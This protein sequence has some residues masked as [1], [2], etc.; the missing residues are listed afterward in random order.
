MKG[1]IKAISDGVNASKLN[2]DTVCLATNQTSSKA[3]FTER[4]M[5]RGDQG[6]SVGEVMRQV[7]N[8]YEEWSPERSEASFGG[9]LHSEFMK[10]INAKGG[11]IEPHAD[12]WRYN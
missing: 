4:R 3:S 11:R 5:M 2:L 9:M 1:I 10:Y 7:H 8:G 12:V 6:Y